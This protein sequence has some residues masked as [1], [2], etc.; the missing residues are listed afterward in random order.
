MGWREQIGA[1]AIEV[2]PTVMQT[3]QRWLDHAID[4]TVWPHAGPSWYKH[5]GGRITNPWPASAR[6]FEQL[7]RRAPEIMSIDVNFG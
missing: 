1:A 2:D 4:R 6:V 5:P 7:L 3:Y